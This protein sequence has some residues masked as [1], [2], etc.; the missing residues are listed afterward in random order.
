MEG[1]VRL[2]IEFTSAD[3][4][5]GGVSRAV[6]QI[7]PLKS[8]AITSSFNTSCDSVAIVY[9]LVGTWKVM[10]IPTRTVYSAPLPPRFIAFHE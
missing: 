5:C 10:T 7:R 2:V 3:P 6:D 8:L 9:I 4:L 1:V